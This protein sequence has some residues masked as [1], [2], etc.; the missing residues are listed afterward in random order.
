MTLTKILQNR[1]E[2]LKIFWSAV[3]Q[4]YNTVDARNLAAWELF[5][6]EYHK[7]EIKS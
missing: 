5:G 1:S 4:G 2:F 7:E 3:N 6:E